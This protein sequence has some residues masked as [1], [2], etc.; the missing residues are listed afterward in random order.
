MK[1]FFYKSVLFTKGKQILSSKY[2]CGLYVV[3]VK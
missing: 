1:Y 2:T 3:Y